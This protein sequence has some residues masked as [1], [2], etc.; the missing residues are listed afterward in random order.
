MIK[1]VV[2]FVFKEM[3]ADAE[4]AL[5]TAARGMMGKIPEL[6]AAAFGRNISPRDRTYTHCLVTEFDDMAAVGRYLVH[7]LHEAFIHDNV[8]PWMKSRTIVDF[9][10]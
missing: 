3:P 6:R 4:A 1:H 10:F 2:N 5:G 7:P 8:Q 9:E